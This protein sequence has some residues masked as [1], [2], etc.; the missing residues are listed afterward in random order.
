MM[1]IDLLLPLFW[2]IVI[3]G[4]T[5]WSFRKITRKVPSNKKWI[6]PE[7]ATNNTSTSSNVETD[8]KK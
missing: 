6:R 8:N 1:D 4:L 5:V 7:E 3:G 2:T